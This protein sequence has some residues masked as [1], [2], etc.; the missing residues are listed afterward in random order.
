MASL[1]KSGITDRGGA[2]AVTAANDSRATEKKMKETIAKLS[3]SP[4]SSR[5]ASTEGAASRPEALALLTVRPGLDDTP[6]GSSGRLAETKGNGD[7]EINDPILANAFHGLKPLPSAPVTATTK[8]K[9]RGKSKQ[10]RGLSKNGGGGGG[11]GKGSPIAAGGGK[12]ALSRTGKE[13]LGAG[14]LRAV[15]VGGVGDGVGG[16]GGLSA[17]LLVG[18]QTRGGDRGIGR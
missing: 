18:T 13:L 9:S 3:K 16:E 12:E 15:G 7:G 17:R 5:I 11:T 8:D 4:S 6:L 14:E 1:Q 10:Q 2:A